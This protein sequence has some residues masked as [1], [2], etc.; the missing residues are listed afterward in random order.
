[1]AS[2]EIP[3]SFLYRGRRRSEAMSRASQPSGKLPNVWDADGDDFDH[4]QLAANFDATDAELTRLDNERLPLGSVVLWWHRANTDPATPW[5]SSSVWQ[6]CDGRTIS[7][8]NHDFPG[9]GTL[10][11]P[12]MRNK[13]AIGA[14]TSD[15]LGSPTVA[16]PGDNSP[17]TV[18][19]VNGAAGGPGIN[20][21]IGSMAK[22]APPNH[23]HNHNHV[24]KTGQSPIVPDMGTASTQDGGGAYS[25]NTDASGSGHNVALASHAH[26][27]FTEYGSV[28][29]DPTNANT[30]II[31]ISGTDPSAA[32]L[33][34]TS[35]QRL[36]TGG[37]IETPA[38]GTSGDTL[39]MDVRPA[40]RGLIYIMKVRNAPA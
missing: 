32:T 27:L 35:L 13:V 2:R 17:G 16:Y 28:P 12:D 1:M 33:T 39:A 18:P 23:Y 29:H 6:P 37:G 9:G 7:I 19:Q 31:D 30:R 25:I 21:V 38:G 4:L 14:I 10:T 34:Q 20:G 5:N 8:G 36:P 40:A 3:A 11:L 22:A 26:N 24:H 15:G